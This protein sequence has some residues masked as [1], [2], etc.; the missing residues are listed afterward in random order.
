MIPAGRGRPVP[1]PSAQ[2][3]A[4]PCEKPPSTTRSIGTGS[5][6]RNAGCLRERREE[7]PGVGRRDASQPVPVGAAR[8]QRQRRPRR[9][10]EQPPVRIERVEKGVQV[11]LV[12]A[13]A[14]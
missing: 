2:L 4:A 10:P 14:V 9:D 7:R 6:S 11:A 13:A 12:G 5:P 8:R 3:I 1:S